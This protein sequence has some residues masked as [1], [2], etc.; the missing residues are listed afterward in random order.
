[1]SVSHRYFEAILTYNVENSHQT[2]LMIR[3][4]SRKRKQI[5]L[6]PSLNE[7]QQLIGIREFYSHDILLRCSSLLFNLLSFSSFNIKS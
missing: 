7:R 6:V 3:Q 2:L 1:M 5:F 4:L